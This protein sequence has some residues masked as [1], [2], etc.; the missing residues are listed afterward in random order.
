MIDA[1][2]TLQAANNQ[3]TLTPQQTLAADVDSSGT[4][5]TTDAD[6]I[7]Q[8]CSGQITAFPNP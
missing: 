1:L 2:I 4:V 6:L 5:T 3:I 7:A 8:Y